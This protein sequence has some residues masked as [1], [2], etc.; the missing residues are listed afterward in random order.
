MRYLKYIL[1]AISVLAASLMLFGGDWAVD[2][3]LLWGYLLLLAA[4]LTAVVLPLVRL[5]RHP[6]RAVRLLVGLGATLLSGLTCYLL[7]NGSPVGEFTDR[8]TLR[9]T[10]TGLYMTCIALAAAVLTAVVGEIRRGIKRH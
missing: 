7:S 3:L 4:L 6:R 5:L 10:D 9:L 2:A 1:T 8:L